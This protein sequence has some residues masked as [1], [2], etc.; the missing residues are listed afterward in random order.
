[1]ADF[2]MR[3]DGELDENMLM[4]DALLKGE[5]T[6]MSLVPMAPPIPGGG[7]LPLRFLMPTDYVFLISSFVAY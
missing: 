6:N 1:M 3:S 7:P 5:S 4:E 2:E